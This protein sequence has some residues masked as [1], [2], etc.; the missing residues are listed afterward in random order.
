MQFTAFCHVVALAAHSLVFAAP[1]NLLRDPGQLH[2]QYY[3]IFPN[4]N[5]NAASH[6]W[7][8]YVLERSRTMSETTFRSLMSAFCPVS[9]SIVNPSD[10]NRWKLTLPTVTGGNQTGIIY[11]CC[12]PCVC[13]TQDFIKV[14]TKT[15]ETLDGSKVYNFL[16]IGNP[17]NNPG[18]VKAVI[19]APDLTCNGTRVDKA[20]LSDHGNIIIGMFH[21]IGVTGHSSQVT[22]NEEGVVH[23][24]CSDRA[25]SGYRSGMG[26]IFRTVAAIEPVSTARLPADA[27]ALVVEMPSKTLG[28]FFVDNTVLLSHNPDQR[29]YGISVYDVDADGQFEAFIAG[30][31]HSNLAYKWDHTQGVFVDL[32]IRHAALQDSSGHAIGLSACD[33]DE[34]GYE[35]LYVVNTDAY[36]GSTL[37]SD[38][39]L[40]FNVATETYTNLFQEPQNQRSANFV[41]GR[42]AG[43]LDRLGN[44]RY[45]VVVANYGAPFKF[46]EIDNNS[47][48]VD[49]AP[50]IGLDKT[51]GGRAMV[52]GPIISNRMDVFA[53]NEGWHGRLLTSR[54]DDA[55][56][57]LGHASG[58]QE[59]PMERP[60]FY[61]LASGDG[62]YLDMAEALGILDIWTTGRGTALLDTNGD[63]RVDIVY[64]NWQNYHRLFVQEE[65]ENGCIRFVDRAPAAM[66]TPS[67]VRTVIVADWDNDGYE[68]ILW[69]NIPG[70]NRLFRKL[71]S[72]ADWT[73]VEMGDAIE[74]YGYGT[75]AAVGDFDQDGLLELLISHGE[76]GPQ[77]TTY[78]KP[79]N[80]Q[81]NHWLRVFPKTAAG[82]PARGAM[83]VLFAGGRQQ[84]R[85]IDSGS[86]YLCQQEP[87]AHFGLGSLPQVEWVTVTWPDG[88]QIKITNPNID[89]LHQVHRSHATEFS[90]PSQ[91]TLQGSC[92]KRVQTSSSQSPQ[93]AV[94]PAERQAATST[95]GS[96]ATND[97]RAATSTTGHL[98]TSMPQNSV[99]S[100]V[101]PAADLA[102]KVPMQLLTFATVS[103]LAAI[104]NRYA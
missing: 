7:S 72:D 83:V 82:A 3:S 80:G 45:G 26:E 84:L 50:H 4:G 59:A 73:Q 43:C 38:L 37:T 102:R 27:S 94:I 58:S 87:V 97:V 79:R 86:G 2:A 47:V 18:A 95:T 76:S 62:T 69:N 14:D 11:Y 39:V 65:D 70:E 77:P 28:G 29:N 101:A 99:T 19:Q 20:I 81:K 24:H 67:A 104:W 100:E 48:I 6:R 103:T 44:G 96:S 90:P 78:Y 23:Q 30:N 5:R 8:T 56:R 74:P 40:D 89:T 25:Q 53:N 91:F 51:T 41:A 92:L 54:D 71:P 98:R 57:R 36:S 33:M 22:F 63:G 75:G 16:V 17:C 15:V 31:A 12:W 85:I 64:G 13:D 42:S 32:A 21:E 46:F 93:P 35:E 66:R 68:E 55:S 61:F 34:D 10:Y 52:M 49:S 1:V 88:A 60:N 9:G